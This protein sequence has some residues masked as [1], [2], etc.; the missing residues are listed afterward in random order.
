MKVLYGSSANGFIWIQFHERR[1][2]GGLTNL[3][4]RVALVKRKA[5][6]VLV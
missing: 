3:K 4:T 5:V 6:D 1:Y 2:R